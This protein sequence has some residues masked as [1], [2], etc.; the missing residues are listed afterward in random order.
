MKLLLGLVLAFTL[1]FA[2]NNPP[3]YASLGDVIYDNAP[4]IKELKNFKEYKPFK[5]KI[6]NYIKEV[7]GTKKLGFAIVQ[8]KFEDKDAKKKVYLNKL[9]ELAKTND[10]FV[11][12]A[13]ALFESAMENRDY[14][15]FV[16]IINT[17]LVDTQRHKDEIL[18]FYEQNKANIQPSGILEEIIKKNEIKKK[19]VHTAE[20]YERLRKLKEQEK[21]RR[22]REK[23]RKR[24]EELQKR[25]E[26][27]LKKKKE[28][29]RKEQLEELQ[30]EIIE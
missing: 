28:Q 15:L 24:Q 6:E 4:K 16:R 30:Q 21:I 7:E 13:N 22:L 10:F 11:R 9:R 2:I 18:E 23:D 20:Y 8:G 3:I 5:E 17:G 26:Q 12:S 19:E 25:L 29:I 14:D 1:T 27:E